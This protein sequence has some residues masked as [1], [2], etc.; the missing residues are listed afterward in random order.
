MC[1]RV[2]TCGCW[3][4]VCNAVSLCHLHCHSRPCLA[5]ESDFSLVS[6]FPAG[7]WTPL[8]FVYILHVGLESIKHPAAACQRSAGSS[9]TTC[10]EQDIWQSA[11]LHQQTS[12]LNFSNLARQSEKLGIITN[13]CN[14]WER[15]KKM[16]EDI[17]Q[18]YLF[19]KFK[20]WSWISSSLLYY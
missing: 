1:M 6:A 18:M 20:R 9:H 17:Y 8:E 16:I 2:H 4:A 14:E 5:R 15:K 7:E 10:L 19:G 12:Y 13:H 3:L 11:V